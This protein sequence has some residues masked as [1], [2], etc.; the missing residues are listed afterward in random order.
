LP[1]LLA[2]QLQD[3]DMVITQGAGNIGALAR[4]LSLHSLLQV[5]QERK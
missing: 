5:E 2:A 3:N 1:A 4:D